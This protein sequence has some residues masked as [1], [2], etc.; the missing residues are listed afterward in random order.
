MQGRKE[1]PYSLFHSRFPDVAERETRTVTVIDPSSFNLP[2]ATYAFLE[3]FCDEPG[4]DCRRVFFTVVSSLKNDIKAVIAWGWED[5]YFYSKWMGSDDPHIINDLKGPV[6]NLASPQSE[7]APALL[8]LFQRVLLQD[9][10]YI[11]R[12]KRHYVMFR[13]TVDSKTKK[14]IPKGKKINKKRRA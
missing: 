8:K 9:S 13:E 12:I 10:G 11:E 6:L 4:C 1:M 5:R 3:M 7:L 2:P 14:K